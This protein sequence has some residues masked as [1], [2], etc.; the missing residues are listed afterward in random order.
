VGARPS[1]D[2]LAD[3]LATAEILSIAL[4][5]SGFRKDNISW[6]LADGDRP[7]DIALALALVLT[8]RLSDKEA[9]ARHMNA[10]LEFAAGV[11]AQLANPEDALQT[12]RVKAMEARVSVDPG[13]RAEHIKREL[14]RNAKVTAEVAAQAKR[15]AS[16]FSGLK[17]SG[18]LAARDA[19]KKQLRDA[20]A[21]NPDLTSSIIRAAAVPEELR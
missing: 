5:K 18:F 14:E 1:L 17:A 13:I 15:L 2:V 7:T 20:M 9:T 8:E 6:V 19:L 10:M 16:H 4:E 21:N 12:V 3:R 11:Q